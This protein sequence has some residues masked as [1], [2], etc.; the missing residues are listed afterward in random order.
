MFHNNNLKSNFKKRWILK[1]HA[2]TFY[3]KYIFHNVIK[4]WISF[5]KR[6]QNS[7]WNSIWLDRTMR[8]GIRDTNFSMKKNLSL[9]LN[10]CSLIFLISIEDSH[11]RGMFIALALANVLRCVPLWLR[12]E[13]VNI[14]TAP[15]KTCLQRS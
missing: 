8:W 14:H 1:K 12:G 2:N 5:K 3:P 7:K 6:S 10:F 13:S 11:Y 4:R 15:L 9:Y